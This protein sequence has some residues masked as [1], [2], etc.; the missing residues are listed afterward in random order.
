MTDQ[1][2]QIDQS[3]DF[4]AMISLFGLSFLLFILWLSS[5][6]KFLEISFVQKEVLLKHKL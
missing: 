2:D 5:G 4:L 6:T 1:I 3:F